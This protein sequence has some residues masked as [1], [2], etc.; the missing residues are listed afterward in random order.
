MKQILLSLIFVSLHATS[1]AEKSS[2]FDC[3]KYSKIGKN[4]HWVYLNFSCQ[5][6][7]AIGSDSD[8]KNLKVSEFAIATKSTIAVNANYFDRRE[9][10]PRGL[11]IT[12]GKVV[13]SSQPA[14]D[15]AVFHCTKKM[16]CSVAFPNEK[17][18]PNDQTEIAISGWQQFVGGNFFCA[19]TADP[20][21]IN[22]A[23][24]KHP[25]SFIGVT[26]SDIHVVVVEGRLPDFEGISLAE[27][28]LILKSLGI[29]RGLNLDGGGST[30]LIIDGTRVNRLPTGQ[31]EERRVTNSIGF[32]VSSPPE[33]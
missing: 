1:W 19:N 4:I 3:I 12:N 28:S 5:R 24:Q 17:W 21:C 13:L 32:S 30:T 33:K 26:G 22:N 27:L 9:M 20:S 16:S 14:S 15:R 18:R 7:I 2:E 29:E 23:E 11:V 25:R 10:K 6:L 8:T 31:L